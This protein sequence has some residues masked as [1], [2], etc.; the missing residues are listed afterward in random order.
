[1][2]LPALDEAELKIMTV[3]MYKF[4]GTENVL[5][6]VQIMQECQIVM[7]QKLQEILESTNA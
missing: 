4:G 5:K 6:A 3:N 1:M 7:L 2:N